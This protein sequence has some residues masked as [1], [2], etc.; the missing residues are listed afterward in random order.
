MHSIGAGKGRA[1]PCLVIGIEELGHER[2]IFSD[3]LLIVVF[4]HI[5]LDILLRRRAWRIGIFGLSF[6]KLDTFSTVSLM[7]CDVLHADIVIDDRLKGFDRTLSLVLEANV[8]AVW[9]KPGLPSTL[10]GLTLGRFCLS[11]LW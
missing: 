8:L 11:F 10:M 6:V 5:D 1:R 7:N 4:H 2:V 3:L 9:I